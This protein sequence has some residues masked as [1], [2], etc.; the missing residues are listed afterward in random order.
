MFSIQKVPGTVPRSSSM[1]VTPA[2]ACKVRSFV[3]VKLILTIKSGRPYS[4]VTNYWDLL[5]IYRISINPYIQGPYPVDKE[6][7]TQEIE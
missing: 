6:D 5:K 3:F 1:I 7:L 4:Q 2:P